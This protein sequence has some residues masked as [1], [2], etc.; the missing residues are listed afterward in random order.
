ML[1]VLP[2]RFF[3]E[4]LDVRLENLDV[5]IWARCIADLKNVGLNLDLLK[6][7]CFNIVFKTSLNF[8]IFFG[9]RQ[10]VL[11]PQMPNRQEVYSPVSS[12]GRK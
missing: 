5:R 11:L 6:D 1:K 2:T 8:I 10:R 9:I 4:N 7:F 12:Y 3:L